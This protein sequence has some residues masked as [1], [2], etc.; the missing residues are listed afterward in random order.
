LTFVDVFNHDQDMTNPPTFGTLRINSFCYTIIFSILTPFGSLALRSYGVLLYEFHTGA[1]PFYTSEEMDQMGLFK[2][3]VRGKF[4]F[5]A[6]CTA[7]LNALDLVEK[8]L[9]LD[10]SDRLGCKAKADLDIRNHP[11]F[12][13]FDFGAL[14][15]KEL[16]PPWKPKISNPFDGSNFGHWS[17]PEKEKA[18]QGLKPLSSEEQK[19]FVEFG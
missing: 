7:S 8:I 2:Q 3:I 14:Y 11:W 9:V 10:P 5:P 1:N 17:D 19:L 6:D 4:K 12:E 16:T 15:R 13:G 18:T